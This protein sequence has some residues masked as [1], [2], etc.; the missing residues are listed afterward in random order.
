[1]LAVFRSHCKHLVEWVL[2]ILGHTLDV[3]VW[4]AYV[5]AEAAI[6][7]RFVADKSLSY[8]NIVRFI[9]TLVVFFVK[10]PGE[11]HLREDPYRHLL[12]Y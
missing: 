7:E 11:S 8:V 5:A 6:G 2:G 12:S 9:L 3:R 10:V 1:M 4:C